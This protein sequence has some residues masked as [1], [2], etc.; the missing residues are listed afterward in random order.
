MEQNRSSGILLH[1]TSLPGKYGIGSLGNEAKLFIDYLA[2]AGQKLWQVLPM[3]HT[4]YGDSPYQCF[5]IFAG[6]PILIDLDQIKVDGLLKA[7]DL[8]TKIVF[9]DDVVDYGVVIN[10]KG[11]MLKIAYNH[12]LDQHE[13]PGS[14]HRFIQE[15]DS[16]LHGYALFV[17]LKEKFDG[18]PWWDWPEQ[19]RSRDNE[20]LKTFTAQSEKEIGFN[21]FCQY[22]FFKHW[23]SVKH[24]A[25]SKGISIIGDIPLYVAH[26]SAD[27]WGNP[28]LFQ[29]DENLLPIK[30]AG[31]PPDYFSET[32]QL[33]GNPLYDWDVMKNNGFKW[34][35]GRVKASLDLYDFVRIDHFRG[36]EA[37]WS[38]T[39]GEE[40]AINGEWSQ[41]PGMELFQIIR[42]Q[43]GELPIIAED[44]GIITHEVEELRDSFAFPGM[45]ILQFAFDADEGNGYLPHNYKENFVTY[46]GTHDNDTLNGWYHSLESHIKN[47]V[48][49]YADANDKNIIKKIIRLAWA[50]VAKMAIIPLQDLLELGGEA[51]MNT[52]GT[53]AGNWQWR[54]TK[55]Q[56]TT[57]KAGWLAHISKLYNR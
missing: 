12:F 31:V 51:R 28:H 32:G 37:Y 48:L 54:F 46:T 30:V 38:V 9:K 27:V 36:F 53:A 19:F 16:W 11:E 21:K 24:H 29:F 55:D 50:S 23:Y 14:Y 22:Y 13:L 3:G 1:P 56:L 10:F 4:G 2:L 8:T 43:M 5:S 39:Y 26:D 15:N 41:A 25:N 20:A 47:R 57:E 49:D 7:D 18:K 6:N 34:W 45:K 17:A 40:T 44:L 35:I 33:W 52:P 42:N